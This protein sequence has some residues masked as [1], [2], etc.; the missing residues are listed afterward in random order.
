MDCY[1]H[2]AVPSVAPCSDCG[3]PICATCRDGAGI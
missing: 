3:Q 1:Y 2:N